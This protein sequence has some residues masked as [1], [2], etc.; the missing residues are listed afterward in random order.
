MDERILKTKF[1]REKRSDG[2]SVYPYSFLPYTPPLP[3]A[4][5]SYRGTIGFDIFPF[6]VTT[7]ISA[8]KQVFIKVYEDMDDPVEGQGA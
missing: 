1:P 4:F 7:R 2:L 5:D 6:S 8:S 3:C